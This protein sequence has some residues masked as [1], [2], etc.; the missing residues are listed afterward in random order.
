[1]DQ[2]FIS[3]LIILYMFLKHKTVENRIHYGGNVSQQIISVLLS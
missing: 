3:F 1:M 2:L